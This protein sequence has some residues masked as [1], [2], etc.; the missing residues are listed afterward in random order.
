[1][2]V[3]PG[4]GRS[5]SRIALDPIAAQPDAKQGFGF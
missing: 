4:M 2:L 1:M 3:Q 5:E